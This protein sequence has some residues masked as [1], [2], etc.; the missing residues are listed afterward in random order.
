[1]KKRWTGG[2]CVLALTLTATFAATPVDGT[3][4]RRTNTP[5]TAVAVTVADFIVEDGT[6][7]ETTL[8][9]NLSTKT[10]RNGTRFTATVRGPAPYRGATV[11]GYVSQAKRSGRVRGNGQLTLNFSRIRLRNGRTYE[12]AGV[13]ES[14]RSTSGDEIKVN[15][16][17][18]AERKDSQTDRTVTRSGVGAGVGAVIG[19]IAGGGKGAGIGAVVGGG[20]GAGSVLVQGRRDLDLQR[21]SRMVIRASGPR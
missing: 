17:G 2:A 12:F 16:E 10:A 21:G 7:V 20:V 4:V 19:A 15:D 14:V 3:T 1:M 6:L 9:T 13:V 5:V 18:T 8:N 11:Y